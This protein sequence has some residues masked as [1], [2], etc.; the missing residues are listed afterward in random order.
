[1]SDSCVI[2]PCCWFK[3][4]VTLI[5]SSSCKPWCIGGLCTGYAGHNTLTAPACM[6]T[7]NQIATGKPSIVSTSPHRRPEDVQ[8]Q[9]DQNTLSLWEL[10]SPRSVPDQPNLHLPPMNAFGCRGGLWIQQGAQTA[11]SGTK[12][13]AELQDT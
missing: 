7:L 11:G 10:H 5:M 9:L 6:H 1:M 4:A 12:E 13:P 3:L 2:A 8:H